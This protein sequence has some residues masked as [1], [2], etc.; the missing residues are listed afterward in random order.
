MYWILAEWQQINTANIDWEIYPYLGLDNTSNI[1]SNQADYYWQLGSN[2]SG[3]PVTMPFGAQFKF[4]GGDIYGVSAYPYMRASEMCLTEAE[5]AFMAGDEIRIPGSQDLRD[6]WTPM[7][8]DTT[9]ITGGT[10]SR[11]RQQ[12]KVAPKKMRWHEVSARI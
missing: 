11:Q 1:P 2:I 4:W 5:A 9:R 10:G 6:S 8:S 7:S 3:G 12:G